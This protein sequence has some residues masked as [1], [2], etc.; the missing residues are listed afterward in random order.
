MAFLDKHGAIGA[1]ALRDAVEL[2]LGCGTR[3]RSP[4]AIGID[5]RDFD[6]VDV[7]GD[8]LEV[9]TALPSES[10][11]RI[12]S[13]HFLEH[14]SDVSALVVEAARVLKTDGLIEVV[15]PHFSNPHYYS[16]STHKTPFGL[17]S[18]SYFAAD[19]VFKRRVPRY[20]SVPLRLESVALEFKSSPPFYARHAFKRAIGRIVN[21]NRGFQELYEECFCWVFPCY[22]VRY[23]LRKT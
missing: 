7:V 10:V 3:K 11:D 1:L 23:R 6:C 20:L 21:M 5:M 8:A 13:F 2:E 9:L 17:Y 18:M 22:E 19:A 15:T 4:S 14:V 12:R 16:D